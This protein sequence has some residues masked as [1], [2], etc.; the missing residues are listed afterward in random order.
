MAFWPKKKHSKVRSKRR[1]SNWVK[2]VARKLKNRVM[3]N[4][5]KT[6]LSHF[7]DENGIYKW[8]QVISPKVKKTNKTRV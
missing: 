4:S 3:L 7:V 1:T 8:R 5:T 2:L 6:W